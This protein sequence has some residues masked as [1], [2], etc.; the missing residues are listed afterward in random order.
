MDFDNLKSFFIKEKISKED[1]MKLGTEKAEELHH[2]YCR[3]KCCG[4]H[5][6][7]VDYKKCPK[8]GMTEEIQNKHSDDFWELIDEIEF[9]LYNY[10][11][12]EE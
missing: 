3:Y 9:D 4:E 10:Y 12:V 7:F 1:F 8:C 5:G 6:D 11:E 2:K